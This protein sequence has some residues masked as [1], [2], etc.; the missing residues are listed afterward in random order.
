MK[1]CEK[2]FNCTN[3]DKKFICSSD[4]RSNKVQIEPKKAYNQEEKL[5]FVNEHK[6]IHTDGKPF[7]C[8]NCEKDFVAKCY[9]KT[10]ISL[11][12]S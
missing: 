1:N 9:P 10:A 8:Y 11:Y 5:K 6:Q 4:I 7:K 2:A 3:C 12:L